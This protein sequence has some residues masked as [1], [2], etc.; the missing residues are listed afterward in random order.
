M[1]ACDVDD[2]ATR[3]NFLLETD[4]GPLAMLGRQ[5]R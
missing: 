5:P 2:L 3:G 1:N 4:L